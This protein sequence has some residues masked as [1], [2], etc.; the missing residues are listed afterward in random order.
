M[1][2]DSRPL[3]LQK[4]EIS[5]ATCQLLARFF[6]D[7][8]QEM[9]TS[10]QGPIR[11]SQCPMMKN[12]KT[13]LQTTTKF[14]TNLATGLWQ[15]TFDDGCQE[16]AGND[17]HKTWRG[18]I[19]IKLSVA[20]ITHP[21]SKCW[22]FELWEWQ[23]LS[24]QHNIP[25][26]T[27]HLLS[28]QISWMNTT[29]LSISPCTVGWTNQMFHSGIHTYSKKLPQSEIKH[30]K[31]YDVSQNPMPRYNTKHHVWHF[32]NTILYHHDNGI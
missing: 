4:L 15:V 13:F 24:F 19:T 20:P 16:V 21:E 6:G 32:I 17:Q 1:M 30:K 29:L 18:L 3:P 12:S 26:H 9:T 5:S 10:W 25:L 22:H 28:S 2:H 8:S 7:K 11:D 23:N 27:F 31:V 14:E